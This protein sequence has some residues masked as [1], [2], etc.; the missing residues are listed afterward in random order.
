M[1]NS[2]IKRNA[3]LGVVFD[4]DM[5]TCDQCGGSVKVNACIENQIIID[6]ILANLEYKGERS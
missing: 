6:K 2:D 1:I 5:E 3:R 4:I